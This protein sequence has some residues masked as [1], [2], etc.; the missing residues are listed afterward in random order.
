MASSDISTASFTPAEVKDDFLVKRES[1][2]FLNAVK[3]RV[4]PFLLKFPQYFAGYGDFVVS[5]EPDRD[6]CIE[7]LQTKVDL[8]I[9]SFNASNTQFNPLSL[10]LQ[11]MLPGGAVAH[12]IFVTKTGRPI[13][14]GCCEQV[15]DKHGNWSG[16]MADYKR[17]EELDGEYAFS[18]GYYEPM[19]AD[20]MISEDQQFVIDLN[21]RVTA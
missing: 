12:N 20:I 14:I 10:I 8:M 17:Q 3:N 9:R 18:K 6:A 16:A 4:L 11:D 15:I 1:S 13:F 5:R 2:G 21:V 19:V 7:I